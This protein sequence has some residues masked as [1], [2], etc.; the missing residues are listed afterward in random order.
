MKRVTKPVPLA[1]ARERLL[2]Y[3]D[4]KGTGPHKAATLAEVI[5][6]EGEAYFIAA[7]GAGAAASRVLKRLGCK[8]VAEDNE[9]G[10]SLG[11]L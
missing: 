7:Q 6:Q 2:A 3:R 10:W 9:W 5:W 4:R 1:V 8:W 11:N